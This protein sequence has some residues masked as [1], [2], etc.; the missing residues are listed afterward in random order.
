[1][2][3]GVQC[4]FVGNGGYRRRFG[5]VLVGAI[6]GS[7]DSLDWSSN[8]LACRHLS[9]SR[10]ELTGREAN[11]ARSS[12]NAQNIDDFWGPERPETAELSAK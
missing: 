4:V 7:N 9:R 2:I 10:R 8:W 1:M 11:R 3:G 6:S 12:L 5:R